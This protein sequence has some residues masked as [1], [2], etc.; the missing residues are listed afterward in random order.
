MREVF[1]KETIVPQLIQQD[2]IRGEIVATLREKPTKLIG[3][4]VERSLAQGVLVC[5]I[6]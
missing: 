6:T 2:L 3:E 5:T 1:G 4:E